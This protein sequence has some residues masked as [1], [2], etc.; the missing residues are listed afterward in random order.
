MMLNNTARVW[1]RASGSGEGPGR[2]SGEGAAAARWLTCWV[3]YVWFCR[4]VDVEVAPCEAPARRITAR[5]PLNA[6]LQGVSAA[7][8]SKTAVCGKATPRAAAL[9]MHGV[10][11]CTGAPCS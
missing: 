7:A 4:R 8:T 6:S 5:V 10:C 1:A 11:T 2:G 9:H 3:S